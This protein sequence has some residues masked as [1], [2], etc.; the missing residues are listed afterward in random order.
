M[1]VCI[2][3][4]PRNG[5]IRMRRNRSVASTASCTCENSRAKGE[6]GGPTCTGTKAPLRCAFVRIGWRGLAG[7]TKA[8]RGKRNAQPFGRSEERR[9]QFRE[10]LH[11]L[12]FDAIERT[13]RNR[14]T[15]GQGDVERR[16]GAFTL[17]GRINSALAAWR[18]HFGRVAARRKP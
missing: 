2:A 1:P 4:R 3:G 18:G 12:A 6:E 9:P 16:I 7:L 5:S 11:L 17:H 8:G 14:Q 15:R 10:C 13:R